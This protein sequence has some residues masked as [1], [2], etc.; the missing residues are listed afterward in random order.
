MTYHPHITYHISHT[1]IHPYNN[2][3]HL[4]IKGRLININLKIEWKV[5]KN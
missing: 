4:T 3:R 1:S 2:L 5:N